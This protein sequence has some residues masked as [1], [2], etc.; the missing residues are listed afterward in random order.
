MEKSCY[1]LHNNVQI[2]N[3]SYNIFDLN[4]VNNIFFKF[5]KLIHEK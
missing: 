3:D 1:N 2:F 5:V 4:I